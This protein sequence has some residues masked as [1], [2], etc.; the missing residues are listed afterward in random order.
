MIVSNQMTREQALEEMK[1]PLYDEKLMD[2]YIDTIKKK[3][4]ISDDEF[5]KIMNNSIHSHSEYKQE[6][7]T[8]KYKMY[9]I[10]WN[11][12]KKIREK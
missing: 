3:L 4:E 5:I 9:K 11:F 2:Y 12:I 1:E 6:I 7:Y 8:I 10:V